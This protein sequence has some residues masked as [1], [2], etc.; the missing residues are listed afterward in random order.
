MSRAIPVFELDEVT[1]T[2]S[3][4]MARI[5]A[6][7]TPPFWVLAA[8]QTAGRGRQGRT[9]QTAPG[10][11]TA[12]LVI[13][14]HTDPGRAGTLSLVAGI[15]V[16]AMLRD[17]ASR[18]GVDP[19]RICLK[20]PN[21]ILIDR[22]KAGGI[23]IETT[24]VANTAELTAV[25]G[26]GLNLVDAPGVEGRVTSSCAA[27][28]LTITPH[29]AVDDLSRRMLDLLAVWEAPDFA[30]ANV[31]VEGI[32]SLWQAYATPAGEPMSIHAG[33]TLAC[34]RFAG[35]DRD[36]ALLLDNDT[37]GL[38]RFTFGDVTLSS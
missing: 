36:G 19:A 13:A 17:A 33:T 20:W 30:G 37:G 11:L 15:A 27:L 18:S 10:N 26:I 21:D 25:I 38:Q 32:T 7:Q 8:R 29:G 24:R 1:S 4:A 2:N 16:A 5:V 9:W 14:T 28:G 34:G 31:G 35:L 12:S 3:E 6:G 22:A 23:L